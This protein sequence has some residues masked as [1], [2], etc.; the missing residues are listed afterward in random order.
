M[1]NFVIVTV[2]VGKQYQATAIQVDPSFVPVKTLLNG[3]PAPTRATARQA[4]LNQMSI[5]RKYDAYRR[6]PCG[7]VWRVE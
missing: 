7:S 5:D 2:P 1:N 6:V 4:V 3:E